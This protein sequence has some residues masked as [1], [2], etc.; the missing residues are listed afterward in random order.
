MNRCMYEKMAS[1]YDLTVSAV[2]VAVCLFG[3]FVLL[4]ISLIGNYLN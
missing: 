2:T 3:G 4:V 1:D